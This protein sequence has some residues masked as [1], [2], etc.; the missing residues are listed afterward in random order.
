M[1]LL[2]KSHSVSSLQIWDMIIPSECSSSFNCQFV[3]LHNGILSHR[4]PRVNVVFKSMGA[5]EAGRVFYNMKQAVH[6]NSQTI[7]TE[8]AVENALESFFSIFGMCPEKVFIISSCERPNKDMETR[9]KMIDRAKSMYQE[10]LLLSRLLQKIT[11]NPAWKSKD[12]CIS[13]EKNTYF[14]ENGTVT[15]MPTP[16]RSMSSH[17]VMVASILYKL[18][19]ETD[20]I[21]NNVCTSNSV[22]N[23]LGIVCAINEL[24]RVVRSVKLLI[25]S[26]SFAVLNDLLA[27]TKD[28][29]GKFSSIESLL[30]SMCVLAVFSEYSTEKITKQNKKD[31]FTSPSFRELYIAM[32]QHMDFCED[33]VVFCKSEFDYVNVKLNTDK[34]VEIVA[35]AVVSPTCERTVKKMHSFISKERNAETEPYGV[36]RYLTPG[37]NLFEESVRKICREI[38]MNCEEIINGAVS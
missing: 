13:D 24:Q 9:M 12:C 28:M 22:F 7:S 19:K 10:K 29:G 6:V 4:F 21:I 2:L 15:N 17:T 33:L 3:D 18:I 8:E 36:A 11:D 23:Y 38:E 34:I 16:P 31:R 26:N 27:Y 25:G 14:I 1:E 5:I 32:I 37:T 35:S 30:K 20:D